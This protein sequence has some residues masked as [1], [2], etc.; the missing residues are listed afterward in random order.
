MGLQ[1]CTGSINPTT[2][3]DVHEGGHARYVPHAILQ[4]QSPNIHFCYLNTSSF[5]GHASV[6][7]PPLQA[8]LP[9]DRRTVK[10]RPGPEIRLSAQR[11][12]DIPHVI[13]RGHPFVK[14]GIP[15]IQNPFH[16]LDTSQIDVRNSG[17]KSAL[18]GI[19]EVHGISLAGIR[20]IKVRGRSQDDDAAEVGQV[21]D[22]TAEQG[23]EGGVVFLRGGAVLAAVVGEEFCGVLEGL[24]EKGTAEVDVRGRDIAANHAGRFGRGFVCSR[25]RVVGAIGH[26]VGG[27]VELGRLREP[28]GELAQVVVDFEDLGAVDVHGVL[29]R[30]EGSQWHIAGREIVGDL[31]R[32]KLV[33]QSDL[34]GVFGKCYRPQSGYFR[35]DTGNAGKHEIGLGEVE[36]GRECQS[37]DG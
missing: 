20:S 26:G 6:L 23:L 4:H 16:H 27:V 17:L 24:A 35:A 32:V 8:P 37:G 25:G 18:L 22:G 31:S 29:C 11:P 36:Q 3:R 1:W 34:D 5:Q 9:L 12:K 19:E 7:V 14:G 13:T 28:D 2:F 10:H 30:A 15:S 33:L 21:G